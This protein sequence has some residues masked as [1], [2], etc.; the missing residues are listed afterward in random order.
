[1]TGQSPTRA[2]GQECSFAVLGT[3]LPQGSKQAYMRGGHVQMTDSANKATKTRPKGALTEWKRR[4]TE[5]AQQAFIGEPWRGPIELSCVFYIARA[6]SHYTPKGV[7]RKGA[8][9]VP[10][11]DL[12]KL[13]RAV[14]DALSKVV[15]QDDVQI[16]SLGETRKVFCHHRHGVGG[17]DIAVRTL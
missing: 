17:V 2:R 3:P 9:T 13:V 14:G 11:G 10:Q 15:Y 5:Q 12:D 7:L 1:M 4:V 16:V 8:P 6:K